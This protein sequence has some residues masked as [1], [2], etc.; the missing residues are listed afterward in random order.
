MKT[1]SQVSF[2]VFSATDLPN[3]IHPSYYMH[4]PRLCL[5]LFILAI[6]CLGSVFY[7]QENRLHFSSDSLEVEGRFRLRFLVVSSMFSMLLR[8]FFA[9]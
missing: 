9:I 1:I 5:Q 2:L 3:F 6:F 7:Y 8:L 4:I